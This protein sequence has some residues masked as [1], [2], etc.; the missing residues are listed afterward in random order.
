MSLLPL[1][2][3]TV[4]RLVVVVLSA[5]LGALICMRLNTVREAARRSQCRANLFQIG[6]ALFNYRAE[7]GRYPPP[8]VLDSHGNPLHSW[9]VLI[10]PH[11]GASQEFKEFDLSLAWNAGSNRELIRR[12]ERY[13]CPSDPVAT[14][15]G[16]TSFVAVVGDNTMW[17]SLAEESVKDNT[18]ET[19]EKIVVIEVPSSTILWT[20][21]RDYTLD[22]V[23]THFS[24]FQNSDRHRR[25]LGEG[26]HPPGLHYLTETGRIGR[27]NSIRDADELRRKIEF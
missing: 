13:A 15:A 6:L 12:G 19:T 14:K 22:E 8:C 16:F 1:G 24:A 17:R 5:A 3:P 7:H 11:L 20:E 27:I 26:H 18:R 4:V 25:Y 9:R 23:I 21:P 2:K 10:L